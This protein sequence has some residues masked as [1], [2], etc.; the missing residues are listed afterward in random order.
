M[1]RLYGSI[2]KSGGQIPNGQALWSF[3]Q[4]LPLAL[5]VVPFIVA[6]NSYLLR[7]ASSDS[8]SSKCQYA[9]QGTGEDKVTLLPDFA[10]PP[11]M[12]SSSQQKG[13]DESA[14]AAGKNSPPLSSYPTPWVGVSLVCG[15]GLILGVTVAFFAATFNMMMGFE[16]QF[17]VSEALFTQ[18]GVFWV[19]FP[20]YPLACFATGLAAYTMERRWIHK[21]RRSSVLLLDATATAATTAN[22]EE[23]GAEFSKW[24]VGD[25]LVLFVIGGAS[26]AFSVVVLLVVCM[27][28]K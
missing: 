20:G 4:E 22:Q 23:R 6:I 17:L 21:R 9:V 7:D 10:S 2:P 13:D 5:L 28:T 12:E 1:A 8:S 16:P 14:L 15:S 18:I 26:H 11:P 3:S 27:G 25:Y 19:V 24:R